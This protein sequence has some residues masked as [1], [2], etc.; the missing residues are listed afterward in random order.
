MIRVMIERQIADDLAVHYDRLSR[1]L[2]QKAM[3]AP[4]F[5][6]GEVL[7]NIDDPNHRLT[8]AT[9]RN[10]SDWQRWYGS[11]ERREMMETLFPLL[12]T[13]ERITVFEH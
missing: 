1:E 3:H 10:I 13:E 4:G 12:Q 2:L 9:Y 8:M 6:S 11:S 5:I 7:R